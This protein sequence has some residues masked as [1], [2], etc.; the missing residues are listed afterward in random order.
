M[1]LLKNRTV[2]GVVC[3]ALSLIICDYAAV[4]CGKGEHH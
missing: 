1:K 4:Q 3:I 2:L